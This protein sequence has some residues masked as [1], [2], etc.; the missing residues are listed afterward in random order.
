MPRPHS[1]A[2][3]AARILVLILR[4]LNLL[5]GVGALVAFVASFPFA[6]VFVEFFSKRPAS[7]DPGWL[8][9]TLRIWMVLVLPMV[10]AVHVVLTRVLAVVET[11]R[12]GDP[13]V[14]DNAERLK[15]IAWCMLAVQL[16]GIVYGALAG[17]MNAAGS[18]IDWVPGLGDAL[19]GWLGVALLFVLAQ[20]FEEGTRMRDD[21]EKMI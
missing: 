7:I 6:S 8:M 2:L 9:P 16:L 19:S 12:G 4:A 20:V 14:P 1:T 15:T 10:A 13:F 5:V 18:N 17:A 21:L 3:S 11:V